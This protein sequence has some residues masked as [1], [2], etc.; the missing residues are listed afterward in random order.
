VEARSGGDLNLDLPVDDPD[1]IRKSASRLSGF[2]FE[3]LP[4]TEIFPKNNS[5]TATDG[6]NQSS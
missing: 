1:S 2:T 5:K 6:E 3:N 4:A